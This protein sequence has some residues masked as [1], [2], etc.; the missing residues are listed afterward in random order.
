MK[1]NF[2]DQHASQFAINLMCELP[3]VARSSYYAYL[4]RSDEPSERERANQVLLEKIKSIFEKHRERYGSPRIHKHCYCKANAAHLGEL[5]DLCG[6]QGFTQSVVG[7]S[8]RDRNA[9]L[10]SRHA[11]SYTKTF[12]LALLIRSGIATSLISKMRAGFI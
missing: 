2:I 9:A 4:K 1:F 8:N 11:I 6:R 3:K 10:S 7:S 5:N 12:A